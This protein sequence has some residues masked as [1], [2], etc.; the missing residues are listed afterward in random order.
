MA[1]LL[2]VEEAGGCV[3]PFPGPAGI[4]GRA[5]V[6]ATA[7]SIGDVLSEIVGSCAEL[8]RGDSPI[9]EIVQAPPSQPQDPTG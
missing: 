3:G 1:G 6:V 9:E 4:T 2:L 7:A 8:A 5:P